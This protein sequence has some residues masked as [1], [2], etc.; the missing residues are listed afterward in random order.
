MMI[1][2][3]IDKSCARTTY[4]LNIPIAPSLYLAIVIWQF[5]PQSDLT[6]N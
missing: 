6:D 3:Y 4:L 5:V 1:L 2:P